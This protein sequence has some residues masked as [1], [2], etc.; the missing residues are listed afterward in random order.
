MFLSKKNMCHVWTIHICGH[1]LVLQYNERILILLVV[2]FQSFVW[3][4]LD[5]RTSTLEAVNMLAY[6]VCLFV[7]F[8]FFCFFVFFL[9][10]F[11]F[12]FE[13]IKYYR[14]VVEFS[15]IYQSNKSHFNDKDLFYNLQQHNNSNN[16]LTYSIKKNNFF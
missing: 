1:N 14:L 15:M 3:G 4:L 8:C 7:L 9:F 10:L 16:F 13:E 2:T 5:I 12:F 6:Y 11:F